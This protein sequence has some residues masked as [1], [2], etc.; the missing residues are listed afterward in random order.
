MHNLTQIA[1]YSMKLIRSFPSSSK[2]YTN[3]NK[4]YI[5]QLLNK[6]QTSFIVHYAYIID[7]NILKDIF[8]AQFKN[9]VNCYSEN[10]ITTCRIL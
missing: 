9:I 6:Q 2:I 7:L 1:E 3:S 10:C 8:F 5:K 4:R